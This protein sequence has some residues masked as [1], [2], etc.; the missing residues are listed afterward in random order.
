MSLKHALADSG[1]R[2]SA[3]EIDVVM[4]AYN[5]LSV[6]PDAEQALELLSRDPNIEA[7]IFSNGTKEMVRASMENVPELSKYS[8]VIKRMVTVEEVRA[9]KP[10]PRTYQHFAMQVGNGTSM[11]DMKQ[12]WLISGNPFEIV[13]AQAA[14]MRAVWIDR[15]GQGWTDK[16]GDVASIS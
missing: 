7:Y 3:P 9:Y 8:S 1:V 13:G 11:E 12:I 6:I 2:L 10:D 4:E 14:G 5:S 16:L 15:G